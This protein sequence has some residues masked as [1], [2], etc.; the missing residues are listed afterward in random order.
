MK[1]RKLLM[2]FSLAVSSMLPNFAVAHPAELPSQNTH[3]IAGNR[4]VTGRTVNLQEEVALRGYVAE[5]NKKLLNKPVIKDPASRNIFFGPR[6]IKGDKLLM[7]VVVIGD[8]LG[9]ASTDGRMAA[10]SEMG[11]FYLKK[12]ET[13]VTYKLSG[14]RM[15]GF[16]EAKVHKT[17]GN[18]ITYKYVVD[19]DVSATMLVGR[20][21]CIPVEL[22]KIIGYL[23]SKLLPHYG[24]DYEYSYRAYKLGYNLYITNLVKVY[25]N[26]DNTGIKST[27]VKLLTRVVGLFSIKSTYNLK[28]RINYIKLTHPNYAIITGIIITVIKCISEAVI[29]RHAYLLRGNSKNMIN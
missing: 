16:R 13:K 21:L 3:V 1:L 20:S 6:H 23:N 9:D 17:K 2:V 25:M 29:G 18:K 5:E 12:G 24:A 26:A 27:K 8:E 11:D 10:L 28:Y 14:M 22:V 7:N 15:T 19:I 4:F